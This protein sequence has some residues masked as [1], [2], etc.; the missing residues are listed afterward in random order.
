MAS[1]NCVSLGGFAHC[2]YVWAL[3]VETSE[4]NDGCSNPHNWI[5]NEAVYVMMED[6]VKSKLGF[7]G[8]HLPNNDAKVDTLAAA[9]AVVV[10]AQKKYVC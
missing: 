8:L 5:E 3:I 6:S 1:L 4:Q 9:A 2:A 10:F 7:S